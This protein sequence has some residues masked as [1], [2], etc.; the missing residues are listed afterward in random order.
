[1]VGAGVTYGMTG[2]ATFNVA[3]LGGTGF[4][5]LH[6]GK[7]G[8]GMNFG[9]NG[10]DVSFQ[11]LS[12]A[13]RGYREAD[14]VTDW[15]TGSEEQRS[16]LNAINVMG[17]TGKAENTKNI[18]LSKAI[19]SGKL[20]ARFED[21]GAN[22]NGYYDAGKNSS[23]IVISS[24]FLGAGMEQAAKL[25]TVMSHEGSHWSGNP[26]E[27]LAHA[28]GL[29]TY[30]QINAIFGLKS[31]DTFNQSMFDAYL[32]PASW[33]V[34]DATGRQDW[35]VLDDGSIV[36]DGS[37]NLNDKNGELLKAS[38]KTKYKESLA[39]VLGIS[40]AEAE[41]MMKLANMTYDTDKKTFI[42]NGV[43]AKNNE[44]VRLRASDDVTQ[45]LVDTYGNS[46]LMAQARY[47]AGAIKAYKREGH[48]QEI[49]GHMPKEDYSSAVFSQ[50]L[51]QSVIGLKDQKACGYAADLLLN[52]K[53]Q[54][55]IGNELTNNELLAVALYLN[56]RAIN[57]EGTVLSH[58]QIGIEVMNLAD[59]DYYLKAD[60]IT[61]DSL[62]SFNTESYYLE[63]RVDRSNP[64]HNH[65]MGWY[66]ETNYDPDTT[67]ES[68]WW[69][70]NKKSYPYYRGFKQT[71]RN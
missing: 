48:R 71:R 29:T 52:S 9:M 37:H 10:T 6:L 16:T 60:D 59:T 47:Y 25:A 26:V 11:T 12:S 41:G 65:I 18:D 17:W 34:N 23:E 32:N 3:S 69:T 66:N 51:V 58:N 28:Q 45:K 56:G 40:V 38:D 61:T 13:V 14:K 4:M 63:Y 21:M 27:A 33:E 49:L 53:F 43:D 44:S 35:K 7:D 67:T 50:E 31:D 55:S 19:W 1:M 54:K 22:E 20:Q 15:K 24:A 57:S 70:D 46:A 68:R 42:A 5:E 30:G 64:K 8:F 2:N 62:S 36:F 39:D